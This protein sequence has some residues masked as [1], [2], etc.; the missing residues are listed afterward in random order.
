MIIIRAVRFTG[1]LLRKWF[2]KEYFDRISSSWLTHLSH[3]LAL[4]YV[5]SVPCHIQNQNYDDAYKKTSHI[6]DELEPDENGR[7]I[8]HTSSFLDIQLDNPLHQFHISN[9]V[10][11]SWIK[12]WID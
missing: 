11:M 10:E 12:V 4:L 9:M 8:F 2:W 3:D 7:K 6:S 5:T 1:D